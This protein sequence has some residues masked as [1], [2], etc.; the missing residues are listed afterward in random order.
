MLFRWNFTSKFEIKCGGKVT[1]D[2]KIQQ[3]TDTGSSFNMKRLRILE[4][5][6]L[7]SSC[8]VTR[9]SE[10]SDML[11]YSA[12]L[13][14]LDIQ[15]IYREDIPC[16]SMSW[17]ASICA[18]ICMLVQ[19]RGLLIEEKHCTTDKGKKNINLAVQMKLPRKTLVFTP[20]KGNQNN[21]HTA[22]IHIWALNDP[23]VMLRDLQWNVD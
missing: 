11:R 1:S 18:P 9:E 3:N 16:Y 4:F 22:I 21:T 5:S 13:L 10:E 20:K 12:Y 8:P 19:K 17:P 14:I 23:T 2:L 15:C 7:W 6:R